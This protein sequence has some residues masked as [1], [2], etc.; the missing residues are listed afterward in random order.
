MNDRLI[1]IAEI[2][3]IA[4]VRP[5]A[6]HNWR[7]RI[8][9]FPLPDPSSIK[10]NEY[11]E[12]EIV[13]WLQARRPNL[14]L[15]TLNLTIRRS[16]DVIAGMGAAPALLAY[17]TLLEHLKALMNA[18]QPPTL[19]AL[20]TSV[21]D[22]DSPSAELAQ[23]FDDDTVST[24]AALLR[25]DSVEL[26][27]SN[28]ADEIERIT[29]RG[30]S[31]NFTTPALRELLVNL[32]QPVQGSVLDPC[33]GSGG[34]LR[35]AAQSSQGQ[36]QLWAAD[37]DDRVSAAF[38]EY[39]ACKSNVSYRESDV[40]ADDP[41]IDM[42][43]DRIMIDPPF[44]LHSATG[45]ALRRGELAWVD[46]AKDHLSESGIAAV[47]TSHRHLINSPDSLNRQNLLRAGSL[48]AIISLPAIGSHKNVPL[49]IWLLSRT[50]SQESVVF[51]DASEISAS[52]WDDDRGSDLV[53]DALI[54]ARDL[55]DYN[56]YVG[57][58]GSVSSVKIPVS[59]VRSADANLLPARWLSHGNQRSKQEASDEL[60]TVIRDLQ[61]TVTRVAQEIGQHS[62][63]LVEGPEPEMVRW[64][65][66]EGSALFVFNGLQSAKDDEDAEGLVKKLSSL[67]GAPTHETDKRATSPGDVIFSPSGV[68]TRST[69]ID[70]SGGHL[71]ARPLVR[72][73][74]D[75]PEGRITAE[76]LAAWLNSVDVMR[77]ALAVAPSPL[78]LQ[79]LEVPLFSK[80]QAE[81]LTIALRTA[82]SSSESLDAAAHLGRSMTSSLM[83]AAL[84]GVT[85]TI[86][87]E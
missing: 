11:N 56:L 76:I 67:H 12:A 53:M 74:V 51:V 7:R 62:N 42:T 40:L 48:S 52:A 70:D 59:A 73:Q 81:Q 41:F 35:A 14:E 18:S 3:Q 71:I 77:Q 80:D 31:R 19:N 24:F 65:L 33:A 17:A 72:I 27:L 44:L 58:T 9:D 54:R 64:T 69:T 82:R 22:D 20:L 55:E 83:E 85:T 45:S 78:D 13:R 46:Y 25:N 47:V 4:D 10:G 6:V 57:P 49:A 79:T 43:F 66:L 84:T 36:V 34:L 8:S 1:S 16:L 86:S 38:A 50:D 37:V 63:Q 15:S 5:T 21:S 61:D 29:R 2:A 32:I 30:G 39:A 60:E 26:I 68:I 23:T 75:H 28:I 87:D